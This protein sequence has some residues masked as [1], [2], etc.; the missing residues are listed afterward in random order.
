[1]QN[2]DAVLDALHSLGQKRIPLQRAYR[3]LYNPHLYAP[4]SG[5]T[6]H[7]AAL[8]RDL[9][10]QHFRWGR[11]PWQDNR[12]RQVLI[13]ILGTYL[14]AQDTPYVH[15]LRPGTGLHS[16]LRA[17]RAILADAQWLCIPDLQPQTA[18]T[19]TGVRPLLAGRI[20]DSRFADLVVRY[21]DAYPYPR[22]AAQSLMSG[23][24]RPDSLHG[25]MCHL[26]LQSLDTDLADMVHIL[27]RPGRSRT[28]GAA[29]RHPAGRIRCVRYMNRLLV[30]MS[31]LPEDTG[32]WGQELK[33]LLH[34]HAL[35]A[36]P[37]SLVDLGQAQARPEFLGHELGS[38]AIQAP[39]LY[40]SERLRAAICQPFLRRGKPASRGERTGLPDEVIWTRYAGEYRAVDQ[41]Y[42]LAENRHRLRR[43]QHT[44]RSSLWRTLAQK[45]KCH[46]NDIVQQPPG[47]GGAT[48]KALLGRVPGTQYQVKWIDDVQWRDPKQVQAGEPCAVKVACTVRRETPRRTV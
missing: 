48:D 13:R 38:S 32:R 25:L 21:F 2:A 40:M 45:H 18:G 10:T 4:V 16:A 44:L 33:A 36:E 7:L 9:R 43:V 22:L 5:H 46:V 35:L 6:G 8:I 29:D 14:G 26:A 34:G 15:G 23:A 39:S 20:A 27:A 31:G 12:V 37:L 24:A 47:A 17:S 30:T 41:Y 19:A 11:K 3:L 42:A 28:R 1:M